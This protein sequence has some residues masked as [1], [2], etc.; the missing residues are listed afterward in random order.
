MSVQE[1]DVAP[2]WGSTKSAKGLSRNMEYRRD[3]IAALHDMG[4]LIPSLGQ[5]IKTLAIILGKG[6]KQ[7]AN[8]LP[9]RSIN[10]NEDWHNKSPATILLRQ[11]S[12]STSQLVIYLD[13]IDYYIINS[14]TI[15]DVNSYISFSIIKPKD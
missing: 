2:S 9:P 15:W 10:R 13:R 14:E 11:Q 8:G 6:S 7:M 3:S 4:P 12:L 1:E 5:S